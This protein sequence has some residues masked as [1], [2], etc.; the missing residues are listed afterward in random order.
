MDVK[1]YFSTNIKIPISEEYSR[2]VS[3]HLCNMSELTYLSD[4]EI[5]VK[6]ILS[7]YDYDQIRYF[8]NEGT[9]AILIKSKGP[10]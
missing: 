6:D 8:N 9:Q 5:L 4:N 1:E 7:N 10:N 2:D 3:L